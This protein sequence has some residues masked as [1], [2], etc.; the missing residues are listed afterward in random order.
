MNEER[1]ELKRRYGSLFDAVSKALFEDDPI[2]IN[3][4]DN[5]DEY[6]PEAGTVIP[7]LSGAVS[8]DDVQTIVFEEFCR[9]FDSD[10]AGDRSRY[11]S[12]SLHIWAIWRDSKAEH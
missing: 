7:R 10:T 3:F 5:T 1:E 8:E 2:G 6:D 12:V 4:G 11:E 9:W